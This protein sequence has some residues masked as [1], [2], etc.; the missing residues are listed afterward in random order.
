VTMPDELTGDHSHR[1]P[2]CYR[3]APCEATCSID[4]DE[5]TWSEIMPPTIETARGVITEC[6]ECRA[7]AVAPSAEERYRAALAT[8]AAGPHSRWDGYAVTRDPHELID[9][10]EEHLYRG[11][12]LPLS[13]AVAW[14]RDGATAWRAVI[15]A[16]PL[17]ALLR[18][19]GRPGWGQWGT[20]WGDSE[21]RVVCP[22]YRTCEPTCADCLAIVRDLAPDAPTL[23]ELLPCRV[24]VTT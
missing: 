5:C 16:E 18:T 1:C 19:I 8:I 22:R 15:R 2:T 9:A 10:I 7:R 13:L 4:P 17:R 24:G 12:R 3:D 21:P 11:E 20:T 23:A 6:D 14:E